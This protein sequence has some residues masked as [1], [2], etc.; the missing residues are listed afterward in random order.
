MWTK[1]KHVGLKM[2][3]WKEIHMYITLVPEE[4]MEVV[5]P[6]LESWHSERNI[7]FFDNWA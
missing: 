4:N 5:F 1:E 7:L 6:I 3:C 2:P